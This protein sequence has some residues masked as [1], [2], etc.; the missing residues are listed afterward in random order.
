MSRLVTH[1]LEEDRP[2]S[3]QNHSQA[4]SGIRPTQIIGRRVGRIVRLR[5]TPSNP[6]IGDDEASA[7]ARAGHNLAE[8]LNMHPKTAFARRT[9][10]RHPWWGMHYLGALSDYPPT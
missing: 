5:R 6:R 10:A 9:T 8:K 1:T 3:Y 7:T 2:S 4:V